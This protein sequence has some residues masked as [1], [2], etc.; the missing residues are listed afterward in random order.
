MAISTSETRSPRWLLLVPVARLGGWCCRLPPLLLALLL[1][2]FLL[3]LLELLLVVQYFGRGVNDR[4]VV[5]VGVVLPGL[6]L[7]CPSL[8][9]VRLAFQLVLV[10]ADRALVFLLDEQ[11]NGGEGK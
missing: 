7:L 5:D 3:L 11:R 4:W 2:L 8:S 9:H 6:A 1:L 10:A